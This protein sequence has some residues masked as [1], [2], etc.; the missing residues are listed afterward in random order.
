MNLFRQ[1]TV[2]WLFISC[3]PFFE[4]NSLKLGE[5]F[6][7]VHIRKLEVEIYVAFSLTCTFSIRYL[8]LTHQMNRRKTLNESAE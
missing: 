6:S 3:T 8:A 2:N 5:H 4:E 1:I 7:D